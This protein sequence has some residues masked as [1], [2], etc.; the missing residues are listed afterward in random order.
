MLCG[1][2]PP[3]LA[4]VCTHLCVSTVS[5]I[6]DSVANI[7]SLQDGSLVGPRFSFWCSLEP[8]LWNRLKKAVWWVL[9]TT[10]PQGCI[11]DFIIP[12][13]KAYCNIMWGTQKA[14]CS[15]K[16]AVVATEAQLVLPATTQPHATV[17]HSEW[18]Y[19]LQRHG[20]GSLELMT[21]DGA[22]CWT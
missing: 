1:I 15:S 13:L 9:P 17:V 7:A 2:W 22:Q 16:V 5:L 3:L 19:A 10:S 18:S 8:S 21:S 20:L 11:T 12:W 6:Q 4:G 14:A